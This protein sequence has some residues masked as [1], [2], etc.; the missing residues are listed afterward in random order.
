MSF[1]ANRCAYRPRPSFSNQSAT[2][3]IAAAPLLVRPSSARLEFIRETR[4]AVGEQPARRY[5]ALP[6]CEV[7][8]KSLADLCQPTGARPAMQSQ[9]RSAVEGASAPNARQRP[10]QGLHR[11]TPRKLLSG[12]AQVGLGPSA[13]SPTWSKTRRVRAGRPCWPVAAGFAAFLTSGTASPT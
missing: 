13:S 1:S 12:R 4:K 7:P 5:R 3:S 2:C 6:D 11:A 8:L 10:P 9:R